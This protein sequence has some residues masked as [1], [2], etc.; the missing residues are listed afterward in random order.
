MAIFSNPMCRQTTWTASRRLSNQHLIDAHDD[1]GSDKGGAKMQRKPGTDASSVRKL[2]HAAEL[3]DLEQGGGLPLDYR[4][5]VP[6]TTNQEEHSSGLVWGDGGVW[7]GVGPRGIGLPGCVNCLTA[8]QVAARCQLAELK[9]CAPY[10]GDWS[11]AQS[12]QPK[13]EPEKV[14]ADEVPKIQGIKTSMMFGPGWQFYCCSPSNAGRTL[15][16]KTGL[17]GVLDLPP[18]PWKVPRWILIL[19]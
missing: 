6:L 13:K 2:R 5:D 8:P 3:I 10:Q 19:H 12:L 14:F 17:L 11:C 18:T 7:V 9:K 15:D 1:G 4:K 16:S